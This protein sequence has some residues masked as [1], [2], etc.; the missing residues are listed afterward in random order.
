VLIV[1]GLGAVYGASSLVTTA[2]GQVGASFAL[3]Q[4]IGVVAAG[5]SRSRSRASITIAGADGPGHCWA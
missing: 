3:R 2:G 4:A 5:C 1:F